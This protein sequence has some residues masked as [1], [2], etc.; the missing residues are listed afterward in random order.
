MNISVFVLL[1]K[2]KGEFLWVGKKEQTP[3]TVLWKTGKVMLHSTEIGSVPLIDRGDEEQKDILIE[4]AKQ[5][6]ELCFGEKHQ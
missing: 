5:K 4:N 2:I 6:A 1:G 3:E